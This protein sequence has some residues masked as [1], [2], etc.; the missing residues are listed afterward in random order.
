MG[1][2]ADNQDG[3]HP[4][5]LTGSMMAGSPFWP[6]SALD[7]STCTKKTTKLKTH[8]HTHRDRECTLCFLSYILAQ[9]FVSTELYLLKTFHISE[10]KEGH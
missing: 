1:E 10:V 3:R 5:T 4:H 2:N 7:P 8:T 6:F 9:Y